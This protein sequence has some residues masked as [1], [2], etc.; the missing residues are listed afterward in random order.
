[1]AVALIIVALIAA[2]LNAGMLIMT[3]VPATPVSGSTSF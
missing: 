3:A 1:M 2:M